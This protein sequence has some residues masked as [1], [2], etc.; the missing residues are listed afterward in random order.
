MIVVVVLL[1]WASCSSELHLDEDDVELLTDSLASTSPVLGLYV[2]MG[3]SPHLVNSIWFWLVGF[4][5]FNYIYLFNLCV[6]HAYMYSTHVKG[7]FQG[8]VRLV[9][10]V[11]PRDG[12]RG[13]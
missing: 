12:M 5:F 10:H 13:Y 1:R 3:V 8:T 9:R 2:F 11:G 4:R 6:T 7:Q